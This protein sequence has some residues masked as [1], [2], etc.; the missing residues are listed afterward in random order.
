MQLLVQL[1]VIL[2][3]IVSI[4]WITGKKSY[5]IGP[6]D[7]ER[8]RSIKS[9]SI[10]QSWTTLLLFLVTNYLFG[11]FNVNEPEVSMSDTNLE[12]FYIILALITY[13]IFYLINSK[14]MSA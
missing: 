7:D 8:K 11:V 6:N 4:G 2:L 14:K 9:K 10:I 3:W 13:F 1:I 5:P 12:L